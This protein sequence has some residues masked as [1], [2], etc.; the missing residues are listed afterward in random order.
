MI[1]TSAPK[2]NLDDT[3]SGSLRKTQSAPQSQKP[4]LIPALTFDDDLDLQ[5]KYLDIEYKVIREDPIEE[6]KLTPS[7]N[8]SSSHH[9]DEVVF[10]EEDADEEEVE[11][12]HGDGEEELG[13]VEEG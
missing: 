5:D 3:N 6:S 1:S 9:F 10:R 13:E 2:L 4:K 12:G 7:R 8:S 11:G